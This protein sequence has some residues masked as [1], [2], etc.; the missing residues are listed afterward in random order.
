MAKDLT[1]EPQPVLGA[2]HYALMCLEKGD[3]V[4]AKHDIHEALFIMGAR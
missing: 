4:G 1:L 3:T 2:L